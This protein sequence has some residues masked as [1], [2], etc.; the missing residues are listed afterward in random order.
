AFEGCSSLTSITIPES[1]TRID[2]NVFDA[3]SKLTIYC[4]ENSYAHN[5]AIQK[6]IK[7]E[8]MKKLIGDPSG[9]GVIDANDLTYF[10]KT[11]LSGNDSFDE[12]L[13]VNGDGK[14]N[15][16]DLVRIKKHLTDN[17]VQLGK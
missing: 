6:N 9:D 8:L 3:C 16:S 15:L 2:D 14:F 7:Y 5:Y 11:L 4:Y 1:V 13:D 10:R 12:R 17:T